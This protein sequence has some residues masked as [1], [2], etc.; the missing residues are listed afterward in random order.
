MPLPVK[1]DSLLNS[2]ISRFGFVMTKFVNRLQSTDG[3]VSFLIDSETTCGTI[4]YPC[5]KGAGGSSRRSARFV[6]QFIIR[7]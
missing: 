2:T 3:A 7:R 6:N 4:H 1:P 5:V